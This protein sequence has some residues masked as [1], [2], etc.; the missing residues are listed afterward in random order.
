[1]EGEELMAD[2]QNNPV[3]VVVVM[4]FSSFLVEVHD[5]LEVAFFEKRVGVVDLAR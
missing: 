2:Q 5:E 3:Q 4:R 1:M